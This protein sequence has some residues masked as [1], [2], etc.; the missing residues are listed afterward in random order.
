MISSCIAK[1]LCSQLTTQLN[2]A[3][4]LFLARMM[5]V[6]GEG[7]LLNGRKH[8]GAVVGLGARGQEGLGPP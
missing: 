2:V 8:E 1:T 6:S 4:P 3:P 7:E 5:G